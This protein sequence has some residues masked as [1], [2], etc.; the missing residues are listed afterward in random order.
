MEEEEVLEKCT[1][2]DVSEL[3]ARLGYLKVLEY[4]VNNCIEIKNKYFYLHALKGDAAEEVFSW[5]FSNEYVKE[6]FELKG[7]AVQNLLALVCKLYYFNIVNIILRSGVVPERDVAIQV[8]ENNS[9]GDNLSTVINTLIET[10]PNIVKSE[11][12]KINERLHR[13]DTF[14][15]EAL[16]LLIAA[17]CPRDVAIINAA[18]SEGNID[19]VQNLYYNGFPIDESTASSAAYKRLEVLIWLRAVGCPWGPEICAVARDNPDPTIHE[20]IHKH[21]PPCCSRRGRM[22][23]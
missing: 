1:K 11:V 6:Y 2:E 7:P 8:I 17:G 16:Q 9:I 22:R 23:P 10:N 18:A 19:L 13:E 15:L 4:I 12:S 14:K 3:A 21:N 20:Y 5:I